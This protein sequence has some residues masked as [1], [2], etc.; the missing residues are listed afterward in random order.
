MD[1]LNEIF[2]DFRMTNLRFVLKPYDFIKLSNFA[3]SSL[4]KDFLA[5]YKQIAC[6]EVNNICRNGCLRAEEC[7]YAILFE[8]NIPTSNNLIKQFQNPPKPFIF[9]SPIKGK[10]LFSRNEELYF[11]LLLMGNAFAY[12]PYFLASMRRLGETGLGWN[13]GKY[14]LT[15]I[16]ANDLVKDSVA[17]VFDF[18]SSDPDINQ[19]VS[20]SLGQLYEH[21]SKE[22]DDVREVEVAILTPLRMKRLCNDNWHLIFRTLVK[23]ILT[24][25]SNIAVAFCDFE[26]FHQFPELINEANSVRIVNEDL[27]WEDWRNSRM[28]NK[29][30]NSKLGGYR[31]TIKY[32]GDITKFW[33]I[34]R[35]GEVLH[36]GKNTSFG[37]G[38]IKVTQ[39]DPA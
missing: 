19:E 6:L 8:D 22:Y 4:R 26:E 16:I 17:A 39:I 28:K 21:Y 14:K 27:I 15:K 12:F 20:F 32:N 5:I 25:I 2:K 7:S 23:N 10:T 3:G 35:L 1:T 31:G 11:D 30:P 29:D 37:L 33:P 13:R 36:I 34:L 9:D 18:T 38:R 24:R